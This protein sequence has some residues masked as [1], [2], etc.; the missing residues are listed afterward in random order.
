MLV[1]NIAHDHMYQLHV[2]GTVGNQIIMS[3]Q[4]SVA[5]HRITSTTGVWH[6][7]PKS[8][9][10][11]TTVPEPVT[12][13]S[14]TLRAVVWDTNHIG[15]VDGM[16]YNYLSYVCQMVY[17]RN[18]LSWYHWIQ[19]CLCHCIQIHKHC[20]IQLNQLHQWYNMQLHQL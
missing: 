9:T 7:T 13:Y 3:N 14:M 16:V 12:W 19:L 8:A 18:M 17:N 1:Y 2:S 10:Y 5:W 11:N 20:S 6:G 4:L 15:Y